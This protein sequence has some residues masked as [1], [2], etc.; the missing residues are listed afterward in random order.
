LEAKRIAGQRGRNESQSGARA[1]C[2]V[3]L[4]GAIQGFA[5]CNQFGG[6]YIL[7]EDRLR[8]TFLDIHATER[9]CPE[10][11]TAEA[12]F[13]KVLEMADNYTVNLEP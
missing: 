11:D 10:L 4:D 7:E 3:R 12:A 6:K 8:I 5:G 1:I 2:I 13:L 9:A